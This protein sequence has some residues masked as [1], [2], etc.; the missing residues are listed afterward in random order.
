MG[1]AG[2]RIGNLLSFDFG[3][4]EPAASVLATYVRHLDE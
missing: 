4:H 3:E 1:A 2:D